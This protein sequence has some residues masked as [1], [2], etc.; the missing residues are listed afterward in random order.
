MYKLYQVTQCSLKWIEESSL[1]WAECSLKFT[2]CSLNL[3]TGSKD[4]T[5]RIFSR[6]TVEGYNPPTLAG[7][8]DTV[9]G[10]FFGEGG[11]MN[12]EGAP[13]AP[14]ATLTEPPHVLFTV[15]RDGAL[16][17]WTLEQGGGMLII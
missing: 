5:I 7:H 9:V 10:V 14:P 12:A 8:R 17:H 2:E 15:S 3:P 4:L 16:F 1:Q 6:E 11:V 13:L